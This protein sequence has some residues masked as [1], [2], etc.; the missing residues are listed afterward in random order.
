MANV[1][2]TDIGGVTFD[3]LIDE[4]QSYSANIPEYPIE[5][6]FSVSDNMSIEPE[7]L[8]LTLYVSDAPVTYDE[9]NGLGSR[10]LTKV[11][12]LKEMWLKR[13]V[14]TITTTSKTYEN[15]CITSFSVNHTRKIGYAREISLSAKQV[16][17]TSTKTV[18][19]APQVE[20]KASGTKQSGGKASVKARAQSLGNRKM[21]EILDK[22]AEWNSGELGKVSKTANKVSSKAKYIPTV[23]QVSENPLQK[24]I[25]N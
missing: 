4:K 6:G 11:E 22:N 19:V 14:I 1:I 8:S 16:R 24:Q 13:E 21:Q 15:Y 2:R 10:S 12:Q 3:A 20:K 17:I 9:G 25:Y 7:E 5:T 23:A 18:E